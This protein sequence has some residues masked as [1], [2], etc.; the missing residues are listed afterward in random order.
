MATARPA[1]NAELVYLDCCQTAALG[2]VSTWN[3]G[4]QPKYWLK[5]RA[6][7]VAWGWSRK[8]PHRP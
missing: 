5:N 2:S 1:M 7:F 3:T 6:T 8:N 4:N